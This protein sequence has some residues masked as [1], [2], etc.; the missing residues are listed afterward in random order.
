MC[1]FALPPFQSEFSVEVYDSFSVPLSAF[2]FLNWWKYKF[3]TLQWLQTESFAPNP[4][5]QIWNMS[6]II[7]L[8]C[9]VDLVREGIWAS[10]PMRKLTHSSEWEMGNLQQNQDIL[11]FPEPS[12]Q[13]WGRV[14][15]IKLWYGKWMVDGLDG[16]LSGWGIEHPAVLISWK[17]NLQSH[18]C[19]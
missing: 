16:S 14:K 5:L 1:T 2:S 12:N 9:G 10:L 8:V 19:I 7:E 17:I 3:L 4:K 11:G 15:T 6:W 13:V 18:R